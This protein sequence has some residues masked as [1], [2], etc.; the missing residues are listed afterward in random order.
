MSVMKLVRQPAR[1]QSFVRLLRI[2]RSYSN[3]RTAPI[4]KISDVKPGSIA[5]L[6]EE[7]R[8]TPATPHTTRTS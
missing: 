7:I 6:S 5:C 1:S 2:G 4:T 8:L 3:R